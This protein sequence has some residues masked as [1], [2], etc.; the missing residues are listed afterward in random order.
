MAAAAA[1]VVVV[2]A[3]TLA[4]RTQVAPANMIAA[5]VVALLL[6]PY[7]DPAGRFSKKS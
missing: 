5:A 3:Y 2:V 7:L 1:A 4:D 6:D